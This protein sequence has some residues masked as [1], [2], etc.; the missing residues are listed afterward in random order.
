MKKMML[1]LSLLLFFSGPGAL[2]ATTYVVEPVLV[3]QPVYAG[4]SFYAYQPYNMPKGWYVTFDGFPI[5]R[6]SSGVWVYGSYNGAA[7]VPTS[8]VV[9]SVNPYTI[10]LTPYVNAAQ[11]SSMRQVPVTPFRQEAPRMVQ[12]VQG[13]PTAAVQTVTLSPTYV[14]QWVMNSNFT[15][16]SSWKT[17]V[18]RIGILENPRTPIAW[19]GDRP[20]VIFV[21]TGRSW[22]EIKARTTDNPENSAETIKE[23]LYSITRMVKNN[24]LRWNDMDTPLL[25][26]QATVWGYL[27]MGRLA[28]AN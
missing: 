19:K 28:P 6:A 10:S 14:P 22:Y 1:A 17:F 12:A 20:K 9:G 2:H 18:D 15:M 8:Y 13:A 24:G 4:M 21:W 26:N 27:W 23:H 5:V 7:L 11:V 16:V 25:A 3:A